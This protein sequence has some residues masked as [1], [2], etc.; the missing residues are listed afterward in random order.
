MGSKIVRIFVVGTAAVLLVFILFP[1]VAGYVYMSN[2]DS[3]EIEDKRNEYWKLTDYAHANR[4]NFNSP[5]FYERREALVLWM[6]V[7]YLPIDEGHIVPTLL[8]RWKI[9]FEYWKLKPE[10]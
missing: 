1:K 5:D 7:R 6:R 9:L 3:V 8:E 10:T 4:N 2:I